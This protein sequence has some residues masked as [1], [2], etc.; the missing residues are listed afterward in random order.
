MRLQDLPGY[1]HV[2]SLFTCRIYCQ[3]FRVAIGL[4]FVMQTYPRLQPYMRFLFVRP[5]I[6]P[7]EDLSTSKIR[8]S[9][10]S[11]SRRT[12]LPLANPSRYRADSGLS[13]YRTCAHR[14]H[15]EAQKR[16]RYRCLSDC[17][18]SSATLGFFVFLCYNIPGDAKCWNVEKWNEEYLRL[19]TPRVWC[20]RGICCAKLMQRWTST[21]FM[22]WS[23]SCT[24]P[25]TAVPAWTR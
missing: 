20:L 15:I 6:C 17:R 3:R 22:I 21:R 11:A 16:H 4:C 7:L 5:E 23:R 14:A 18:E 1:S 24:A 8:L 25:T 9:S 10:D 19:W 2:L 12:P 13:P